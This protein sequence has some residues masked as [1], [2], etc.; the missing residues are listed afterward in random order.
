[1]AAHKDGLNFAYR[2]K[3]HFAITMDDL[4]HDPKYINNLLKY[5]KK[6]NL[7]VGSRF[8]AK[9]LAKSINNRFI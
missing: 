9:N 6:Y 5:N 7:V 2:K 3:Y 4:A 1:M 8:L